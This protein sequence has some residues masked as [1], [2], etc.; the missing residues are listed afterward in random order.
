MAGAAEGEMNRHASEVNRRILSGAT[1]MQFDETSFQFTPRWYAL[2][3]ATQQRVAALEAIWADS[4][5]RSPE[6]Y[7]WRAFKEFLAEQ[8]P[9]GRSLAVALYD[10]GAEESDRAMGE[11]IMHEIVSLPEC[12]TEVL[13]RARA[14]ASS[15]VVW[16][17]AFSSMASTTF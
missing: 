9:L 17:G 12:P 16:R 8:R 10:L 6:H 13:E 4:E 3:I 15:M 1:T 2:G 14:F 11:S 7:R 5:D